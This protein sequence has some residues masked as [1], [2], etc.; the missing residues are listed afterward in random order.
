MIFA[1]SLSFLGWAQPPSADWGLM[2]AE[3]QPVIASNIW[4]LLAPAVMIGL[5]TVG[6]NLIGDAFSRSLGVSEPVP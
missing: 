1:A 3:N 6:V 5:I 2:I 4:A